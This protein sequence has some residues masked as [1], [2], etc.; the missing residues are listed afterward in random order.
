MSNRKFLVGFLDGGADVNFVTASIFHLGV[1]PASYPMETGGPFP[2]VRKF[3]T[4]VK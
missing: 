4:E 2:G 3:E 1:H